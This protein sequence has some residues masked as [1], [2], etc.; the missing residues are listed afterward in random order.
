MLEK[1]VIAVVSTILVVGVVTGVV[2]TVH[3]SHKNEDQLSPHMNVVSVFCSFTH[4][5]ES[6][7]RTLSSANSTDPNMLIAKAISAA[8]E[9]VTKFFNYSDSLMVQAKNNSLTKMALDD[10]KDMMNYAVDSLQTSYSNVNDNEIFDINERVNDLR[11]WLSAVMSYQQSCLDGF[12]HDSNMKETV[13]K[14]M[15]DARELTGNALTIVTHFLDI[16]SRYDIKLPNPKP[17][18]H[19]VVYGKKNGYPSWFS[20]KD[21][22]LL[23][24]IGNNDVIPNAVVAHDGSGQFKTIGAALA[25]APKNS[26]AIRHVIYVKAGIYDEC[27]T[28]GKDYTNIL[29]YGDG[30]TKTIVTG[31]KGVKVG[32]GMTTWRTATFAVIGNQFVAKSMGFQNTAGPEMHQAV[33]LR[34][35]SDKSIFFDCR[36][37]SYQNT[38]HNQA[39]R[40]FFRNCVISGT[41]DFIFGDSP[42]IIQNSL[43]IV[44]RPMDHQFNTL[45]AQ[46]KDYIDE[47]TGTVIQNCRIIPEQRLYNDRFEIATYLGRPWKKFSTTVIMESAI[48]DFIRPEGWIRFEG[49]EKVDHGET[50]Y[51]GEYNNRGP[52]AN[53]H[54]RVNWKGYHKMD[55]VSAMKFTLQSFLWSKGMAW[56]PLAGIPFTT[57]LRY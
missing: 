18:S 54:A 44:R 11:T 25:A 32:G 24:R 49:R 22:R 31:T 33:A 2:I 7:H 34:V 35:Q 4:Y 23:A 45:T 55:R 41:V 38:L 56:L 17:K 48:G 21:R 36:I 27:I 43:I 29:M 50:V 20:A 16:M 15:V 12:E 39:N 5:N 6:C 10:C 8:E 57:T 46:G 1:I 28:V 14:G 52:G 9:S 26:D 37:D 47:N 51:Y 42:A 3:H 40:Q 19:K 13:Q 30:P 53:L